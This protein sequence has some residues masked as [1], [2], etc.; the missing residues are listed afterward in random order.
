M[1][2]TVR[3]YNKELASDWADVL[4]NAKNGIFLFD[5]DFIEY[6]GARFVEVSAIAYVAGKPA[7]LIPAAIDPKSGELASHP[8]LTFG[9]VV[10]RR[11]LRG[12]VAIVVI[13]ELLN[14]LRGWGYGR[15]TIKLLP[16]IFSTYPSAELD[17]VLWRRG[18]NLI[19]RDLSSILPFRDALPFNSLKARGVKKARRAGLVIGDAAAADFHL[20]LESVLLSQHGV[21]PVHTK[22]EMELLISRFPSKILIRVARHECEIV[23]GS[24]ILNYGHIW[25][26]Q[27]LICSDNGRDIGALDLVISEV[28]NEAIANKA[29]YLSFGVSTESSGRLINEGLLW[30]KES[31]GARSLTLD[32][33]EGAL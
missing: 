1:D 5:R 13:D 25:H 22:S 11:E 10:L 16:Q 4:A 27:Y 12:E 19:R 33:M 6:H 26:T 18:F 31:F 15:L 9:G 2:I 20:L 32:F 8:G 14:A 7:A 24:M 28:K 3:R 21:A 29:D 17:Y 30:Q 23:A